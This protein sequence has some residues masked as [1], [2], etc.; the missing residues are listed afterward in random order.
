MLMGYMF[1]AIGAALLLIVGRSG[2]LV[3]VVSR[4]VVLGCCSFAVPAMVS[5]AMSA[6]AAHRFGQWGSDHRPAKRAEHWAP[7]FAALYS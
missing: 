3:L 6:L 2:P 7:P 5:V 4:G 1:G